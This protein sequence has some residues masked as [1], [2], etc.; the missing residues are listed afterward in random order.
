VTQVGAIPDIVISMR[1]G[2]ILIPVGAILILV[3]ATRYLLVR[4]L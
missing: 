4:F 3:G 1:V 2:A